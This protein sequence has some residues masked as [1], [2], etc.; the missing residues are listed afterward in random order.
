LGDPHAL[1]LDEPLCSVDRSGAEIIWRAVEQRSKAGCAVL[2]ATHGAS[3]AARC[4][5]VVALA[6]AR[7]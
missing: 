4:D 1:L 7:L 2:V 5:R 6:R 3:L